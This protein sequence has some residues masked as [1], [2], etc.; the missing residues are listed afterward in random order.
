MDSVEF[1]EADRTAAWNKVMLLVE[2]FSRMPL[3]AR[4]QGWFG[5]G[6]GRR[7]KVEAWARKELKSIIG[8]ILIGIVVNLIVR[9][10]VK[11]IIEWWNDLEKG[12][13]QRMMMPVE[14]QLAA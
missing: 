12:V 5:T 1:T 2:R 9:W 3:A 8:T 7:S 6:L 13:F 10:A 11:L 14:F 4:P